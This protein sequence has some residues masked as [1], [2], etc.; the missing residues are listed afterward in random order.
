MLGYDV[1]SKLM[2]AIDNY[3]LDSGLDINRIQ[4]NSGCT[5]FKSCEHSCHEEIERG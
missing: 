1:K 2:P 3:L 5:A 4:P